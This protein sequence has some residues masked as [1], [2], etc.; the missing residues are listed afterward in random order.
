VPD[1]PREIDAGSLDEYLTYQYVPHPN[2]IFRGFRK[3]PPGHYAV[4]QND[5]LKVCPY[6]TPDFGFVRGRKQEDDVAAVRESLDEAVRIRMRSDVPLGA[7]LSGGVDSSVVVGL[8]AE[9]SAA[10]VKT[11]SIGF[12]EPAFDELAPAR[13]VAAHFGTDHHEFVVTPD[14][15]GILDRLI[16][17]FDEPFADSSA[18]PTWYVSEMARRH[19]TVVLSGST[20]RC[21]DRRRAPGRR[22]PPST[23]G[24]RAP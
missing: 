5:K 15:I 21:G 9:A 16:E 1:V 24:R 17:H 4:Y 19:V 12:D 14:A 11:F 7:F 10:P 13:R 6:W 20:I 23:S 8:M 2:T 18:I 22:D 3:L